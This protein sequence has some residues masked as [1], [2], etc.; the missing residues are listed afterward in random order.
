MTRPVYLIL[1]FLHL[2][3]I[4]APAPGSVLVGMRAGSR[5]LGFCVPSTVMRM[6]SGWGAG[7]AVRSFLMEVVCTELCRGRRVVGEA[8]AQPGVFSPLFHS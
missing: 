2:R 4:T 6:L 5:Q 8:G 1:S 3:D 7:G